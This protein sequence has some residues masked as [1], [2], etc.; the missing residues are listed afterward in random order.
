M[1]GKKLLIS[2]GAGFVGYYL[3]EGLLHWNRSRGNGSPIQ[4]IVFN[5]IRGVPEWAS[6]LET[7]PDVNLTQTRHYFAAS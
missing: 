5:Y 7:R 3:I 6:N 1:R 4:L 2:G